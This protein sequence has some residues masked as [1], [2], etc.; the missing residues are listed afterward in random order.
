MEANSEAAVCARDIRPF[1]TISR[2]LTTVHASN[3]IARLVWSTKQLQCVLWEIV[4][5]S[6]S[7]HSFVQK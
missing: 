3:A 7:Y 6:E 4:H 5:T 2:N 1:C